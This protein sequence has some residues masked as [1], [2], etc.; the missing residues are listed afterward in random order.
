M[1][2]P[3]L[4]YHQVAYCCSWLY[5]C[6]G[7]SVGCIFAI[8]ALCLLIVA[9]SLASWEGLLAWFIGSFQSYLLWFPFAVLYNFQIGRARQGFAPFLCCARRAV[10]QRAANGLSMALFCCFDDS[11]LDFSYCRWWMEREAALRYSEQPDP[12]AANI[13]VV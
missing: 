6:A 5:K 11:V 12:P 2:A 3:R 8:F 10:Q 7:R 13:A 4:S 1:L 9:I